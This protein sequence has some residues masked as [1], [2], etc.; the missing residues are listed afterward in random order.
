MAAP[1]IW[2]WPG[3]HVPAS[4]V[5]SPVPHGEVL[6]LLQGMDKDDKEVLVVEQRGEQADPLLHAGPT[7]FRDLWTWKE[8]PGALHPRRPQRDKDGCRE[9]NMPP[10]CHF[11]V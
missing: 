9:P 6:L 11:H 4:P 7:V 5:A 1:G 8:T 3:T 2:I 10:R